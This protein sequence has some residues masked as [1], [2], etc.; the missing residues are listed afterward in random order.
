MHS[1]DRS[2]YLG[3]GGGLCK[4]ALGPALGPPGCWASW[5]SLGPG[6]RHSPQTPPARVLSAGPERSMALSHARAGHATPVQAVLLPLLRRNRILPSGSLHPHLAD[7]GWGTVS[8]PGPFS[9]AP[10]GPALSSPLCPPGW[11]PSLGPGH[12]AVWMLLGSITPSWLLV[13][14]LQRAVGSWGP[15]AQPRANLEAT[16]SLPDL[17]PHPRL[18]PC[19]PGASGPTVQPGQAS[20][21]HCG[22]KF[23]VHGCVWAKTRGTKGPGSALGLGLRA[24]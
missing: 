24:L 17:R 8:G 16:Q 19:T 13:L 4:G 7:M 22:P 11:A 23:K 9:A 2:K 14:D 21:P 6:T 3:F 10:A 1:A 20:G 15:G 18:H 12:R 5:A